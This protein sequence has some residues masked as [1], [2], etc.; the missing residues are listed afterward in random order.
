MSRAWLLEHDPEKW[1]YRLSEK[2]MLKST[3]GVG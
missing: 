3:D 1:V 2:I